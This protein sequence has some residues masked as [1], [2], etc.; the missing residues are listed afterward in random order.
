MIGTRIDLPI[1]SYPL[2]SCAG[3]NMELVGNPLRPKKIEEEM[4]NI[5]EDE[6]E[7]KIAGGAGSVWVTSDKTFAY[8]FFED[9]HTLDENNRIALPREI[10]VAQLL[11]DIPGI[12]QVISYGLLLQKVPY[13]YSKQD[14][15]YY[16]KGKKRTYFTGTEKIQQ[17]AE[18]RIIKK[19]RGLFLKKKEGSFVKIRLVWFIKMQNFEDDLFELLYDEKVDLSMKEKISILEQIITQIDAIHKAGYAHN[20]LAASNILY[21]KYANGKYIVAIS[22]FET[23]EENKVEAVLKHQRFHRPPGLEKSQVSS[24]LFDWFAFA[25]IAWFVFERIFPFET[26]EQHLRFRELLDFDK[27]EIANDEIFSF[28]N[29]CFDN[30]RKMDTRALMDQL[31]KIKHE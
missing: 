24:V 21:R 7:F 8:K 2:V 6:L 28:L 20:D 17:L 4:F 22:D 10:Q 3:C 5:D 26:D 1:V 31:K 25:V 23:L 27:D 15:D 14:K 13:T 11:K 16:A 18:K 29:Y 19:D 30:Y 9:E 12:V